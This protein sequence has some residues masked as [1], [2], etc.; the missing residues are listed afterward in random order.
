[1]SSLSPSMPSTTNDIYPRGGQESDKFKMKFIP[2]NAVNNRSKK[3]TPNL[4]YNESNSPKIESG[5][6]DIT[7][8]QSNKFL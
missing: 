7:Q 6:I 5:A 8:K 3:F 1:M 2:K 4:I